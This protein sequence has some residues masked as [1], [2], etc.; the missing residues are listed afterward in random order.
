MLN[1]S[2]SRFSVYSINMMACTPAWRKFLIPWLVVLSAAII[3]I[4]VPTPADAQ[5]FP[6]FPDLLHAEQADRS[7][8]DR[9]GKIIWGNLTQIDFDFVKDGQTVPQGFHGSTVQS[10]KVCGRV[11]RIW[12]SRQRQ[13]HK[14]QNLQHAIAREHVDAGQLRLVDSCRPAQVHAGVPRGTRFHLLQSKYS[15]IRASTKTRLLCQSVQLYL[16][17]GCD[18]ESDWQH[19]AAT[20]LAQPSSSTVPHCCSWC[21]SSDPHATS[22]L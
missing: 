8:W 2:Q 1:R 6:A 13:L 10:P 5:N 12:V 3:M 20:F 9:L 22:K 18:I 14:H 7:Q 17:H 21:C 4:L 16:P 19:Q 15:R 11:A